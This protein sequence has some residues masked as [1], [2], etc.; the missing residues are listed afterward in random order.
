MKDFYFNAKGRISRKEY[1]LK[2][3]LLLLAIVI[4]VVVVIG[5]IS[6]GIGAIAGQSAAGIVAAVLGIPAYIGLIWAGVCVSS[7]RFHDRNMS[8]WWVLYFMLAA[9]AIAIVQNAV[10]YGLG[11]ENP[12]TMIIVLV[13]TLASLAVS[14][15]QL[16]ILGFLPGN[17]GPNQYGPDPL[18]PSG[19]TAETFA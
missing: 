1:W 3:V 8:G 16:V 5:A 15:T 11:A 17:K 6:A 18:D 9:I 10:L 13:C 12:V 14:I 4:G 7:K 19:G 2:G